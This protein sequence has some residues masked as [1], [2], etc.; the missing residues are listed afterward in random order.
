VIPPGGKITAGK[1]IEMTGLLKDAP[2]NWGR[3][4]SI[5]GYRQS[6]IGRELG[7]HSI[8]LYTQISVLE[9]AIAVSIY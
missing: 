4:A 8:E 2:K 3:W 5:G 7:K 9:A 1:V 6:G